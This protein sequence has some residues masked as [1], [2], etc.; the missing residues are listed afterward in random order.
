MS[1]ISALW[2]LPA[3]AIGIIAAWL[4]FQF[5]YE[6]SQT[7]SINKRKNNDIV[8]L[9]LPRSIEAEVFGPEYWKA[10]HALA[11]LIPCSICRDH[12]VPLEV[13]KHDI[14]NGM[15]EKPIFPFDRANWKLWVNKVNDLDKK[16]V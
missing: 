8:T 16:V 4:Y 3:L 2:I 9:K 5:V 1:K 13:F 10:F 7:V 15:I 12:A 14:V 11:A 6:P